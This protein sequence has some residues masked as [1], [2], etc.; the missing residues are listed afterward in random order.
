MPMDARLSGRTFSPNINFY[1][2]GICVNKQVGVLA[3]GSMGESQAGQS[4][5]SRLF[6]TT[7]E[8]LVKIAKDEAGQEPSQMVRAVVC[9]VK[10]LVFH[11]KGKD[12]ALAVGICCYQASIPFLL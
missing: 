10:V 11:L 5:N 12:V 2:N 6:S 4:A 1:F 9:H 8:Q 7:R 3:G